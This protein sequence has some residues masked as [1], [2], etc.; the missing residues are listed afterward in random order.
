M[1][2]K[3][4]RSGGARAGAGRKRLP[5]E[6]KAIKGTARRKSTA[7]A[8]A[9]QPMEWR[10]SATADGKPA[11]SIRYQPLASE[12]GWPKKVELRLQLASRSYGIMKNLGSLLKKADN[13]SSHE[14]VDC[15][16][17]P[18]YMLPNH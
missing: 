14:I 15:R 11:R 13:I 12:T 8:P 16:T 6:I 9:N 18:F 10:V 1:V 2:G 7:L 5:D 17:S 3:V 4:G